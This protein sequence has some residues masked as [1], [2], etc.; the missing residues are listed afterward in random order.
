MVREV[1]TGADFDAESFQAWYGAIRPL[2]PTAVAQLFAGS[3]LRW[4]IAGGRA[5]RIGARESRAHEDTD[6]EVPAVQLPALRAHLVDWHLWQADDGW[7]RPLLP[8]DPLREGVNQLWVRRDAGSPWVLDVLLVPG[9]GSEWVYRRDESTRLPWSRAHHV[10]DSIT[11]VRPEV[12][13]LFKAKQ[14]RPKDRA[15]R[16]AAEL[17]AE[18]RAWLVERLRAE[19]RNQWAEAVSRH[20]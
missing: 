10:A 15:D 9:D 3:G 20:G 11:Y 5:A 1:R 8:D 12:A 19:G 7:L 13:L 14:D 18:G 17:T 2:V 4:A 6:V 16:E